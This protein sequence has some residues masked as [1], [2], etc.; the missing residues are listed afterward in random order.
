MSTVIKGTPTVFTPYSIGRY[1]AKNRFIK[2]GCMDFCA[3]PDG[4]CSDEYISYL[5]SF[6]Q[7]GVGTVCT[8]PISFVEHRQNDYQL[9]LTSLQHADSLKKLVDSIHQHNTGIFAFFDYPGIRSVELFVSVLNKDPDYFNR[10]YNQAIQWISQELTDSDIQGILAD[11]KKAVIQAR[12]VGFDGIFLNATFGS[13]FDLMSNECVNFRSDAWG[14]SEQKRLRLLCEAVSICREQSL[15]VMVRWNI[16][17]YN[18]EGR[19]IADSVRLCGILEQ[20]GANLIEVTAFTG[21]DDTVRLNSDIHERSTLPLLESN[22]FIDYFR[23]MHTFAD[24][25]FFASKDISV[26]YEYVW[27]HAQYNIKPLKKDLTIPVSFLGGIRCLRS[28]E[29]IVSKDFGDCISLV[30]ELIFDHNIVDSFQSGT[31]DVIG[32]ISCNLCMRN[33]IRSFAD[34]TR[35]YKHRCYLR[36]SQHE[37]SN[38]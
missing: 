3:D 27:G 18:A 6:A 5:E 12:S 20:A 36:T 17:K 29:K 23:L 35:K 34:R 1:E 19:T 2:T 25:C 4:S 14:G 38:S 26:P 9:G 28:A 8:A 7:G 24:N 21:V 30:Q 33:M 32:C 31:S 10:K 37:E 16:K 11:F 22:E 13:F 15:P